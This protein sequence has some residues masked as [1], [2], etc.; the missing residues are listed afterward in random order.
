MAFASQE[1]VKEGDFTRSIEEQTGKIPSIGYLGF[2]LASMGVSAVLAFALRRKEIAN[3]V[4]LWAPSILI[5]GV[6][7]KLVKLEHENMLGSHSGGNVGNIG[8]RF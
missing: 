7:N 2:A 1:Q 5:M 3:F 6:Y 4:G 8:N